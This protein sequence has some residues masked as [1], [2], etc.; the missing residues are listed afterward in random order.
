M[1]IR[2]AESW[3][4]GFQSFGMQLGL[5]RISLLMNNLGNPQNHYNTIHVSGTN[6]K[7][8]LCHL[9]SSILQES[10]YRCGMY[11]SPHLLQIFERFII[12]DIPIS[13]EGF[14]SITTEVKK[15]VDILIDQGIQ[16]TYFEVCTAIAFLFFYKKNIDYAII[17]VGLGGR[18]DAT[19]I[20][21][22]LLSIITNISLEHQQVLG[23]TIEEITREKAGI[24]KDQ[25]PVITAAVS[26]ALDI[27]KKE[28]REKKAP[29]QLLTQDDITVQAHDLSGQDLI[30]T[31]QFQQYLI[32]TSMIGCY[33]QINIALAIRAI[34]Q[35]QMN[36]V[37]IPQEAITKGIE[38][39]IVPGRLEQLNQ[40]PLVLVDGAHTIEAMRSVKNTIE[41]IAPHIRVIVV[42]GMLSDK[43]IKEISTLVNEFADI[44]IVTKS[45][46][47]R[48]LEPAEI[49]PYFET[50]QKTMYQITSVE[51]AIEKALSLVDDDDLVLITGSLSMVGDAKSFFE[52]K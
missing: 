37:Y 38:T 26:P 50:S 24:I 23:Q 42:F 43:K 3:I 13:S 46:S 9:L 51:E 31:G 52:S 48:T 6:G 7:G 5:E 44:I 19:N 15:G 33:Q 21:A 27:I 32:K 30:I 1:N 18:F 20:I 35:L 17:E 29:L 12:N 16:P 41:T 14:A 22:P 8:S 39:T 28:A 40:H 47:K 25:V 10:G 4:D 45:S 34:E 11:T 36:G 2:E 49:M